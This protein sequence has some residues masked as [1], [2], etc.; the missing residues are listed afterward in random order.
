MLKRTVLAGVAAIAL[1]VPA[2]AADR[3]SAATAMPDA[4]FIAKQLPGERL[5]N[6]IIG[7]AVEDVSG[8]KV[9]KVNDLVI[10]PS[11]TITGAVIGV[12]GFIGIGEKNVAVS[13]DRLK[14]K[15]AKGEE[16]VMALSVTKQQLENAPDYVDTEGKPIGLTKQLAD[17]AREL[18]KNAQEEYDEAKQ[19]ASEAYNQAKEQAS[20]AYGKAKERV[21]GSDK[22]QS[23]TRNQ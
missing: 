11:G 9:G 22:D 8:Q 20:E 12:G 16:K 6:T 15:T 7:M 23:G 5:A 4:A 17:K 18:G 14:P 3:N 2:S 19:K 21:P 1:A 10:G 13:F